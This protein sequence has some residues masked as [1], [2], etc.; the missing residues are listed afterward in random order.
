MSL[1]RELNELLQKGWDSPIL[2]FPWLPGESPPSADFLVAL[3]GFRN[4]E[5][6]F[7]WV[8]SYLPYADANECVLTSFKPICCPMPV[9][10]GVCAADPFREHHQIVAAVKRQGFSGVINFPSAGLMD[11]SFRTTIEQKHLGFSCEVNF[12]RVAGEE[13]LTTGALVFDAPQAQQMLNVGADILFIHPGI[14][15]CESNGDAL[16]ACIALRDTFDSFLPRD[17]PVFYCLPGPV[18]SENM[19]HSLLN[20]GILYA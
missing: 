7:D 11:G 6:L 4:V 14:E 10:A 2:G 9:F 19:A 12:I 17:T 8:S 15:L 18:Q 20:R 1:S 13:Q 16:A 5:G 3:Y